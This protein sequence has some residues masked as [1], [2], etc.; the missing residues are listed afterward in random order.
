MNP[1]RFASN[2]VGNADGG[3]VLTP[4]SDNIV[5]LVMEMAAV[6]AA[7]KRECVDKL[8]VLLAVAGYSR[9]SDPDRKIVNEGEVIFNR[10]SA[11]TSN[12]FVFVD[13]TGK[14]PVAYFTNPGWT[15]DGPEEQRIKL[16]YN[17]AETPDEWAVRVKAAAEAASQTKPSN[18]RYFEAH[19][20]IGFAIKHQDGQQTTLVVRDDGIATDR[21]KIRE[22]M[23]YHYDY[24]AI[25][26]H[27]NFDQEAYYITQDKAQH[28]NITMIPA[29]E[30]TIPIGE[31]KPRGF[32]V[33][34]WFSDPQT[35]QEVQQTILS[36]KKRGVPALAIP[37]DTW[38]LLDELN[39]YRQKGRLALGLA[40]PAGDP[41]L[42][43]DGIFDHVAFGRLTHQE[44][45]RVLTYMDSVANFN[46]YPSFTELFGQKT[47]M[48][49]NPLSKHARLIQN[50]ADRELTQKPE[51]GTTLTPNAMN[52]I[53]SKFAQK[54]THFE[55]D[56]HESPNITPRLPK[57]LMGVGRTEITW[58]LQRAPTPPELVRAI[59][60][61]YI[62]QNGTPYLVK[63]EGHA[64]Y[65]ID[66]TGGITMASEVQPGWTLMRI[67]S[68]IRQ[69]GRDTIYGI[70]LNVGRPRTPPEEDI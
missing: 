11:T 18:V 37:G 14:A 54:Q 64:N 38:P 65:E 24:G 32:H 57:G 25:T 66:K 58:G 56:E 45:V 21:N 36:R 20:H 69:L 63:I 59:Q 34:A 55:T 62:L 19:T 61:G 6:S 46:T 52:M 48:I 23:Y 31:N 7:R 33:V 12:F 4:S 60:D 22:M 29:A 42:P 67:T 51:Y 30:I 26:A 2:V 43:R 10:G 13:T 15:K 9:I 40:H 5:P 16:V 39:A 68:A 70:G 27:N 1:P 49:F 44:F 3:A 47:P 8:T 17:P 53:L 50:W 35:A 41:L 28:A